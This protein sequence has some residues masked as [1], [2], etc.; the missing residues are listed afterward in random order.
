VARP[1]PSVRLLEFHL[2]KNQCVVSK[3]WLSIFKALAID[4]DW[5]WEFING[6]YVKAHQHSAGAVGKKPQAIGKSRAG[7]YHED[8][9]GG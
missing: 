1:A 5:E 4:P 6:S 8:S 2:Q 7:K 3:K 9:F